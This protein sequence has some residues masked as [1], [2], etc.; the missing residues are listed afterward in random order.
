MKTSYQCI[1]FLSTSV[2]VK[3]DWKEEGLQWA[4][5]GHVL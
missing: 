1:C 5:K 3:L 2:V 4:T